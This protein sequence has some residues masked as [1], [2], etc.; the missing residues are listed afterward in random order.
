MSLIVSVS[1]IRG[2]IGGSVG[3]NLT[4]IDIVKFATAYG[5]FIKQKTSNPKIIIGR[6]GRISGPMV[7]DLVIR[8]LQALGIDLIDAGWS[9]TP[10]IEMAVIT[11]KLDGGIILTASHNPKEWNALKLLNAQGEFLSAQDGEEIVKLSQSD[12]VQFSQ[13]DKLGK[14]RAWD[15][16]V[17]SH[18]AQILQLPLVLKNKIQSKKFKVIVDCINSTGAIAIPKLMNALHCDFS[19]INETVSGDFAHNPEPLPSHLTD[20]IQLCKKEKCIGIAIDPDVDRLALIDE[21]GNYFGE[22]YTLVAV[23]D[24]ILSKTPGNTV[25]NLSSSRALRDLTASY[26]QSYSASAVGEAHVVKLM[27]ETNAVIGGEGNGG[28]IYPELHYGR[29]ALVGISLLLSYL[30]ESNLNLSQLKSRYT[31]YFMYKDKMELDPSLDYNQ[32]ISYLINE[33]SSEQINTIDG[34]K[35]DFKDSWLHLRKSNTE[36]II[37]IYS[38]ALSEPLAKDLVDQIK[39]KISDFRA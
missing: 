28:I 15:Q 24:Y 7:S 1:G 19:L 2:T 3:S 21:Q 35:I 18:I 13:I 9:T 30:A 12:T 10:S 38:E 11:E 22:E 29:D 16:S 23:A 4:P 5:S 25:S 27:K 17:D 36:P 39:I 14:I 6:D 34:L 26:N 32:L 8:T 33:Y 20:L 31:Q 37:R